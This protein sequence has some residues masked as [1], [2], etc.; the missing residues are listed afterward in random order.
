MIV[1]P[2]KAARHRRR[3]AQQP[4][5]GRSAVSGA[6]PLHL[7]VPAATGRRTGAALRRPGASG[8][9]VPGRTGSRACPC[10]P[11]TR[12]IACYLQT[13]RGMKPD[14]A[15]DPG[16]A[17]EAL[18]AF[19]DD[20]TGGTRP[21]GQGQQPGRPPRCSAAGIRLRA[22]PAPARLTALPSGS[23]SGP[24]DDRTPMTSCPRRYQTTAPT[25]I[26]TCPIT[27]NR[28]SRILGCK[29]QVQR[30]YQPFRSATEASLAKFHRIPQRKSC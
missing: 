12:L 16:A 19:L 14:R 2:G 15:A 5:Q 23:H 3:V 1:P 8:S 20:V 25:T 7:A 27:P 21:P 13:G 30:P 26:R 11:R 9:R 28:R 22:T 4:R 24:G 10:R 17:M 18:P 29:R 6:W